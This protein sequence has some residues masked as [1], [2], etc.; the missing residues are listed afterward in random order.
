MTGWL[1][2]RLADT[3]DQCAALLADIGDTCAW[4]ATLT[5]VTP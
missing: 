1:F 2:D 3:C 4:L 5:R